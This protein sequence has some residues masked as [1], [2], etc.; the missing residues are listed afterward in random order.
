M[1]TKTYFDNEGYEYTKSN[2]R[3]RYNPEFHDRHGK[4]W[5]SEELS[6]LCKMR[7][8]MKYKDL[9][10]ALGRTV[11]V[12]ENKYYELKKNNLVKYYQDL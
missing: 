8:Q 3:M 11:G 2:N 5:T 10:M 1:N 6:Y 7:P 12:C 9:S 4:V